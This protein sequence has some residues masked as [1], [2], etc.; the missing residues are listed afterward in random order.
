MLQADKLPRRPKAQARPANPRA[1]EA[2]TR[3]VNVAHRRISAK[4]VLDDS[5]EF[6]RPGKRKYN[7]PEEKKAESE[8]LLKGLERTHRQRLEAEEELK[9]MES[10]LAVLRRTEQEWEHE[11]LECVKDRAGSAEE[12]ER[13]CK[14]KA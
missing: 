1:P 5:S 4:P 7:T 9:A 2:S 13:P 11:F 10:R 12:V 6:E 3:P 14:K 8:R